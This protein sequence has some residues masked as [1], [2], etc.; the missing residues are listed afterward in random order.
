MAKKIKEDVIEFLKPRDAVRRRWGMYIG[1]NSNANVLLREII[2]NSGDEIS[3]GY[4]DSILVSGDFNGFCF[5]ADNGRGIPIAMSPDKPGST[6]AYLSISELHSGSKFSN[7]EVSRVGMN[8]VG[9]SATNFL[10]EEYWLLSRIGEHNYNKSIPDVEKAWNNAG[11]RSKGDLYYFVK[12]V[13]GEKVLESAGRLGD[14]EKLMFKGV[15]DYQT[16]PRDLSTIV[17]FKPDPEIFESTKAEV[18]ITNLQYFLMIQEKFYNR[19]VSVFVDGKK[20]NNTFKPFKYELVRNI[21]PKDDSFNKQVGIYVTFEVDP[22]LGNKVEMGSVNGLDVNQGQHIT[23]AESCFKTALKDM[24]KIKHEYLLNGL[25][26]CVILLAGEVMFDSQTKTRLKSITKVKVTDFGD[27]VKDMEKIMRKNSDYWDLHVSKLNKLAE[28]MKDIGAA[29]LAEKMMDGASGV[30][31]YRSKNDLVPGFAE[32]TGKDRMACELFLCFTGDT[33]ILTC[34][35]EKI[36]FKDLVGRIENGE[37]LYTFSCDKDGIIEPSKII[38]AK[39]ISTSD[40]LAIITLDNGEVI[41]CTPDHKMMLRDGTYSEACNLSPGDSLMPIYIKEETQVVGK[42]YLGKKGTK[43]T[44][45]IVKS[46]ET[47]DKKYGKRVN[48][49]YYVYRVM[50]THKDVT[51]HDSFKSVE[52]DPLKQ[53]RHHIDHNTLNDSPRN[54]M[55]CSNTWHRGHHGAMGLHNVAGQNKEIYKKVYLDSKRSD[56]YRKRLSNSI[57]SHYNTPK[58]DS[59]KKHLRSQAIKEWSNK[60]LRKWRSNETKKYCKEHPEFAKNNKKLAERA[61][62]ERE[63]ITNTAII[64]NRKLPLD[65]RNF[66]KISFERSRADKNIRVRYFKTIIKNNPDLVS[67]YTNNL[68]STCELKYFIAENILETLHEN[69]KDITLDNFNEEVKKL[70]NKNRVV[71]GCGY[72]GLRK[73]Y[74]DLFQKFEF[75]NNNHK[76]TKIEV[77]DAVEDVYCLEVDNPLH[78]FPLASGVFTKNCEGL[79]ASGSLVT[80]RP[81]TTKIAVLPLRGKILNV[82]NASAKR[83]MES[84]TIYSI[85]KVIGLGLDVNNVTKDC[86]TIEEAREVIKQ[87]SRYGKIIV[88]SDADEQVAESE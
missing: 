85:F 34:N 29:E 12:C 87:K 14:I 79:S 70:F 73:K 66:D 3:A 61:I 36:A 21:T 48:G 31:L 59:T 47:P 4:G 11:P 49:G 54:L 22:K 74:P 8:G 17:F 83:A 42:S 65:A 5:V 18:P 68:D 25:R 46:G 20:I 63:V 55:L 84:Q 33:E 82:T 50:S 57:K 38:A 7:T 9:S 40:K 62:E 76:V 37:E 39:K 51:V 41:R 77:I 6:Q 15:K 35:N 44:R 45:N 58:G 64:K 69:G 75:T 72:S 86:N 80:A 53:V 81:D 26:V 88:A 2:D 19:K 60:D 24:Y 10:S 23:I 52:N 32:A 1:D 13:K 78:N 28:S 67:D 56:E 16:V 71:N 43:F 30:G 27:V